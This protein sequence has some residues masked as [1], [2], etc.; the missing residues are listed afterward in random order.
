MS[1]F[2]AKPQRERLLT[3]S[4][5]LCCA[6]VVSAKASS[7]GAENASNPDPGMI[8]RW[9][10]CEPNTG[11]TVIV[12][13]QKIGSG[14]IYVGCALG[15]QPDG[16]EALENA[17]FQLEGTSDYGL[18]FVCRID[19]QPTP[20]ETPCT[21]TPGGDAYWSYWRGEPGGRWGFS[22]AGAKSPQTRS[23]VNSVEG[24]SFGGGE[25][26]RIEPMDGSGPS[27]F[28]LPPGQES[29]VIPSLLAREWLALTLDETAQMAE[30]LEGEK[31][32]ERPEAEELLPGAIALARAG[33]DPARLQPLVA[34][35]ARS[36]EVKHEDVEGCPLRELANPKEK[37]AERYALAVLG[38]QALGQNPLSFAG[39]DLRLELEE[40]LS[41]STGEVKGAKAIEVTAPTVLALARTGTLSEKAQRT[42]ELILSQQ[43]TST[44]GWEATTAASAVAI[45]ALAAAREQGASVLGQGRLERV[46]S[47][48]ERA[49]GYLESIQEPAGGVR[50]EESAGAPNVKSTALGAVALALS[51][52]QPAAERAAKWVSRYQVTA[53]YAGRG[54]PE[55][56]EKT[57]AEGVIGAFLP[58][59]AA[60]RNALAYGVGSDNRHGLYVEARA[61]TTDALLA[62][63]TAGPYGPY[64]ASFEQQS[65]V[66]EARVVGSSSRPL[67]AVLTNHDVRALTVGAVGV[68]GMDAGDFN[69]AGCTGRTLAPGESCELTASFDPTA[70]GLREALLQVSFAG[71]S[72]TVELPVSGNGTPEVG[73]QS[74]E[75]NQPENE[76]RPSQEKEND[77]TEGTN[78]TESTGT[79]PLTGSQGV[80]G[81]R[82][83]S[84]ARVQTPRLSALGSGRGLVGVSWS[85]LEPGVGSSSWTITSQTL[86]A[87]KAGYVTRAAGSASVTSALLKLPAGAAYE[88]QITFTDSLGESATTQI[89]K[90]VVPYD[91]RSSGLHYRGRWRRLKQVGAWLETVSRGASGAK[92]S[93]TL[94]AG[95][96]VFLLRASP[97]AARV[98]VRAG[99]RHEVF[100]I[101]RGHPGAL[102]QIGAAERSV[103]GPVSLIVLNGTVNLDGVAVEG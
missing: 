26:P 63:A 74:E 16:V 66:F 46:E 28:T 64:D 4:L 23:P 25:A 87:A 85:V 79:S 86:G 77:G 33:L 92:V 5:L 62:L 65:L 12:D 70:S 71:S 98:E 59:E 76:S 53:E 81:S 72:Q 8:A 89:G 61:P 49:G 35:L 80:L 101:A 73:N 31:L 54:N 18:A 34:W 97:S 11:V 38:L 37:Y 82:I 91:D 42:L 90:V 44:G 99:S 9:E 24:W 51:G 68:A 57:P 48:L 95:R 45:E 94:G 13:D 55:T 40:M 60:L 2:T 22:G 3:V 93:V 41:K 43:G 84:L 10:P 32:A 1:P 75:E 6:L 15:E 67:Q 20:S 102:Q 52:R 29:S 7:A 56:D 30:R 96:P 78:Q 14:M 58:G 100:E 19:G 69:V 50:E 17:G 83:A 36:C 27:S 103:A 21:T 47:A 88:L 39:R